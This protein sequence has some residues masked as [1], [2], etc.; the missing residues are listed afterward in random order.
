MQGSGWIALVLFG[1]SIVRCHGAETAGRMAEA[2]TTLVG[3][4]F[5]GCVCSLRTIADDVRQ[6]IECNLDIYLTVCGLFD[7]HR[8]L[9][10]FRTASS[11]ALDSQWKKVLAIFGNDDFYLYVV[12]ELF[13]RF[14]I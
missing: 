10:Q 2:V 9:K 7:P 8:Q 12:G 1:L 3:R 4:Y 6:L 14:L 11:V 13:I 5:T